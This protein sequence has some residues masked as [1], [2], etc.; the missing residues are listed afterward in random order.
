MDPNTPLDNALVRWLQPNTPRA[1]EVVDEL[2]NGDG[3][4]V[5]SGVL[6]PREC[7][8]EYDRLWGF[9]SKVSPS[10]QR[11]DPRSWY[12]ATTT[13][14]GVVCSGFEDEEDEDPL[15]PWP[16]AQRDRF[17]LHHSGWVFN[18]LR[19]K[20]ASRVFEPLF[21]TKELHCSKDGF[22]F[23]RPTGPVPMPAPSKKQPAA[24]AAR[25]R[26]IGSV[27]D[28][29]NS[30]AGVDAS[31]SDAVADKDDWAG[32]GAGGVFV[33]PA[34]MKGPRTQGTSD[35][36]FHQGS[37]LKGLQCVQGSVSLLDQQQ[38]DGCFLCWPGS[39]RAHAAVLAARAA[40]AKQKGTTT[41]EALLEGG[42]EFYVPLNKKEL[43]A[44][45][46]GEFGS[47]LPRRAPLPSS[48]PTGISTGLHQPTSRD[49]SAGYAPRRVRVRKGDVVLW[50]SDLVH[51]A[52]APMGPKVR[53]VATAQE[54]T[55]MAAAAMAN[56][57]FISSSS[58]GAVIGGVGGGSALRLAREGT[59][60]FRAVV[61]VCMAPAALT[62]EHVYKEKVAAYQRLETAGH[63]PGREE[64]FKARDRPPRKEYWKRPPELTRRQ[65]QLYGLIRYDDEDGDDGGDGE[66]DGNGHGGSVGGGGIG[67]HH[68]TDAA[69]NQSDSATS[70][71]EEEKEAAATAAAAVGRGGKIATS[72]AVLRGE[73][74]AIFGN[75][76]G[77]ARGASLSSNDD[78]LDGWSSHSG[79]YEDG[80]SGNVQLRGLL[81]PGP[82][83]CMM[84][85]K[86]G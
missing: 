37:A 31:F 20:I 1:R 10:V 76:N 55:A 52:C 72:M 58:G 77:G 84:A 71:A 78:G 40:S 24:A 74:G 27:L 64:W 54:A 32:V 42:S 29:G 61:Y 39:H 81:L 45:A 56:R 15:D 86:G 51:S 44:L 79:R 50:R 30:S 33:P 69:A 8:S 80:N 7:A 75:G 82:A 38:G 26:S 57:P 49:G 35:E 21:G 19:E 4:V 65:A 17:Q 67:R 23:H 60:N 68:E 5:I 41:E 63:W 48:S 36:R 13:T 3:Y 25:A 6:S 9:V 16:H 34:F 62:A 59:P 70:E 12:P 47:P 53:Q 43:T 28:I 85:R 22:T 2:L 66:G 11:D 73:G 83:G 14:G 46:A 18:D